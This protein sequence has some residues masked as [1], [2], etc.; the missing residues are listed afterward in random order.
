MKKIELPGV[1]VMLDLET[2]STDPNAAIIAIG[3]TVFHPDKGTFDTPFYTRV[4][5]STSV[6]SGGHL[7][8]DTVEWW[9]DQSPEARALFKETAASLSAALMDLRQYLA[10]VCKG[11]PDNLMLWGNG[12]PFDNVI[13]RQAYARLKLLPP[14]HFYNDRCYRTFK[15]LAPGVSLRRS[16]VH[17]NALSDAQTQAAHLMEIYHW[18]NETRPT[19]DPDDDIPF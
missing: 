1:N 17:H 12:A 15:A 7:S 14:W 2:M 3:A 18:I 10:R 6:E 4:A 16:G 13:L 9:M 5:L 19:P 8:P 11:N